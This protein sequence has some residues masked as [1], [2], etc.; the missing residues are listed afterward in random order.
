MGTNNDKNLTITSKL[1]AD[2]NPLIL[3]EFHQAF[4]NSSLIT[5]FGYTGGYKK[6]NSKK[7]AGDKSHFFSKFIKN[8]KRRK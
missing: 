5:D 4:K 7:Q 6:T 8:F 3:G 2:E 1:Y